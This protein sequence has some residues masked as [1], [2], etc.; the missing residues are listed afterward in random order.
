MNQ[1]REALAELVALQDLRDR[2]G[3]ISPVE[4]GCEKEVLY[5]EYRRRQP[6]AWAIARAALAAQP[7]GQQEDEATPEVIEARS[8]LHDAM[9]TPAEAEQAIEFL[10]TFR[11]S[12]PRGICKAAMGSA[13]L[14]LR[15][16]SVSPPTSTPEEPAGRKPPI[17]ERLRAAGTKPAEPECITCTRC[18]H[19]NWIQDGKAPAQVTPN[20]AEPAFSLAQIKQAVQTVV[21]SQ[22]SI[23]EINGVKG[24]WSFTPLSTKETP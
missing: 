23:I 2:A 8:S 9:G 16:A 22:I 12:M 24:Y 3:K 1:L 17:S 20:K 4:P 21:D 19:E 14:C 11:R 7:E 6:I 15:G 13:I 18:G 10:C 5:E